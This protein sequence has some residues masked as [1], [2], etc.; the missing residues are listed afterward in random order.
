MILGQ[1]ETKMS[2]TEKIEMAKSAMKAAW[3]ELHGIH[4][5]CMYGEPSAAMQTI[6]S[7]LK[8]LETK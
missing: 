7:A 6:T 3:K 2:K 1:G 8:A 4:C 5:S